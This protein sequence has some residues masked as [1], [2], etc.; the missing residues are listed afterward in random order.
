MELRKKDLF[1][2]TKN[3]ESKSW[4]DYLHLDKSRKNNLIREVMRSTSSPKSLPLSDDNARHYRYLNL[5][6]R[7]TDILAHISSS[8]PI[9]HDEAL[10]IAF[11]EKEEL[12]RHL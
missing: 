3:A 8:S 11:N 9:N 12:G 4:I 5:H 2:Q 10:C 1:H 6:V 7:S